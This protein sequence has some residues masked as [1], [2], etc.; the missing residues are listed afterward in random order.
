MVSALPLDVLPII[1][2]H[3]TI[4]DILRVRLVSVDADLSIAIQR[5]FFFWN[6]LIRLTSTLQKPIPSGMLI[7]YA[8]SYNLISPFL[9][10]PDGLSKYLMLKN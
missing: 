7:F 3:L 2:S 8:T 10:F 4:L 9:V 5:R 1:F 6:R